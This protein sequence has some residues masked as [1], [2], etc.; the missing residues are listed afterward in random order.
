M[1]TKRDKILSPAYLPVPGILA[2]CLW[3]MLATFGTLPLS[4]GTIINSKH[5]LS[6]AGPGSVRAVTEAGV[7]IFC[8]TPHHSTGEQPLWNHVMPTATNYIVYSSPTLK[9]VVG[10]PDGASRLCLSCHDGTVAIG[11]VNSQATPIEM[12][13]GVTTMPVGPGNLGTD[14][15]G[16][17]PVSFVY[18]AALAA[19]D[20][21]LKDPSTL[22]NKVKLDPNAKMQCTSCHDP[23]DNQYGNF[24]VQD[25][26]GSALCINCHNLTSWSGSVHA[27]SARTVSAIQPGRLTPKTKMRTTVA[28]DG[29]NN[30]HAPHFAGSRKTLMKFAV[31]EKNCLTCHD[32]TVSAKNVAADF[33]K[34]SVHPITANAEAHNRQEDPINPAVR[35]VT[36]VDCHDPHAST[37]MTGARTRASGALTGV[38]GMSASGLLMK[39]VSKE[40]EL[41]FRCHADS[42]ARGPERVNRQWHETNKR[43]DFD[44]SNQSFH[45]VVAIGRNSSVPS[46]IA[47][48]TPS[49]TMSCMDCHNSDQSPGAGGR[50]ANGP[51]GSIYVP[52]L[53]RQLVLEDYSPESTASYALCYKCHSRDSILS[54]QSFRAFNSLG[55]DRG[56]RFH[57]V[58]QKTACTTCHDS[59]GVATAKHL[60]NFNNNY[61]TPSA[62]F[63]VVQ[64]TSA[65][66]FS[67]N[68]TLTCHGFDHSGSSYSPSGLSHSRP[69]LMKRR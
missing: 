34:M 32:G 2:S 49:S 46:L 52:L 50:G 62:S 6:V 36:C 37:T 8:H 47:P 39:S 12:Q 11:M 7:C 59:H 60:I 14:L 61:V 5:D 44:R 33:Q 18:D 31:P 4:A 15:S 66:N 20:G 28:A 27:L 24:L 42:I 10:Q 29:C 45:P 26:T 9:A 16:D 35:H 19:A 58:D 48:W 25:N 56:H 21:Q 63:P 17:H 69:A 54:D 30:C 57:V 64:Y 3:L 38:S 68:C 55:Q 53:E 13:G 40:Y 41:C 43:L 65:G 1:K 23:H 22:V 51:H 67:G